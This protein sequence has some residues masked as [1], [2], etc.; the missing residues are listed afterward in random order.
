MAEA[1]DENRAM[2]DASAL[3]LRRRCVAV[4]ALRH[5]LIELGLVL[6]GAQAL[7]ELAELPLLLLKPAQ[8]LGTVFVERAIAARARILPPA[9]KLTGR[10]RVVPAAEIAMLS[11]AHSSAPD[12]VGQGG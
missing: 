3:R 2:E 9:G 4:A 6:G 12:C 5:E 10:I 11:A 7:Q 8:G 1:P